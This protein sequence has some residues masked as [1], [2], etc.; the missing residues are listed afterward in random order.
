MDTDD[1]TSVFWDGRC[2]RN[3]TT[4]DRM[5]DFYR[6][7]QKENFTHSSWEA[8]GTSHIL[9]NFSLQIDEY[10]FVNNTSGLSG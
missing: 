5:E 9:P 2:S 10:A 8:C 3:H 7:L 1:A 6:I 4:V